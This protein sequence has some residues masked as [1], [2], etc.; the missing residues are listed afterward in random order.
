MDNCNKCNSCNSCDPCKKCCPARYDCMFN[1]E[2]S[3]Y[4]PDTWLVTQGGMMH[5]IKVPKMNETDTFL[6]VN[7]TLG[8]LV[9][10]AEKHTDNVTGPQLGNIINLDY[11]RNV[12][13]DPTLTGNCYELIFHKYSTCGEGCQ[14]LADSWMNFNINS[15]GAK[16]NGIRYVRGANEYGC[17]VYLDIPPRTNEYWW[18]M[19]R[20]NDTGTGLEFGYIQPE[21]VDQL[22]TDD[23][24]NILVISQTEN[25]K[26]V[27][28]PLAATLCSRAIEFVTR[29][30]T[31]T[32]S[33]Y[34]LNNSV[35]EDEIVITPDNDPTWR[36]PC[37]GLLYVGYCVNP[38]HQIVTAAN[39]VAEIDVTIMLDNETYD[40]RAGSKERYMSTHS[41]W[42]WQPGNISC[43]ETCSAMRVVPEGRTIKLHARNT[44]DTPPGMSGW[45]GEWR[46]H[47][48]RACFIPLEIGG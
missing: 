38:R 48:I 44:G 13:I 45:A 17:P 40:G 7:P 31:P 10:K 11:L 21:H 22:P 28:G 8:A 4:D 25:G 47:A 43:S 41:T 23:D 6:S 14:S 27:V 35:T 18:G 3:P 2:V 37:C 5:K 19:W 39:S 46:V 16:R 26:P 9:Y 42:T 34:F 29:Q 24:G 15:E 20:P 32:A 12:D 33:L 30:A 36:A 1:I